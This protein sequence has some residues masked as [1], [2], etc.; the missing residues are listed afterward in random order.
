[1]WYSM[2]IMVFINCHWCV[3]GEWE[4]GPVGSVQGPVRW[5]RTV[6]DLNSSARERGIQSQARADDQ[7]LRT[8]ASKGQ[9]WQPR[10]GDSGGRTICLLIYC[11]S[12][13]KF[14]A[15]VFY[16]WFWFYSC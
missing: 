12:A 11:Q 16:P 3:T 4:N 8:Q 5:G 13:H 10:K 15:H 14:N 2:L 1:M 7:G 9:A 6:P